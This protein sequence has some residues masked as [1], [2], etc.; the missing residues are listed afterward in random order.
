MKHEIPPM[1]PEIAPDAPR[2]GMNGFSPNTNVGRWV[3]VMH[4]PNANYANESVSARFS[5]IPGS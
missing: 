1:T 2:L 4:G 3:F 5:R